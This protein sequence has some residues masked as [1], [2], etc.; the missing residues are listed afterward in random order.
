M[1]KSLLPLV[2]LSASVISGCASLPAAT[3]ADS[4]VRSV[5]AG[6]SAKERAQADRQVVVTFRDVRPVLAIEAGATPTLQASRAGYASSAYARRIVGRLA[7]DYELERVTD[8]FIETLGVHCVVYRLV[9][10]NE[11]RDTL[12]AKLRSDKRVAD[13]Q[14]MQEFRTLATPA[15]TSPG[16]TD[17]YLDLQH[18]AARIGVPA[19][20]KHASGRGIRVAVVDTGLDDLHTDLQGR[21]ESTD[22]FVDNDTTQYRRDRHGTAVGGTIAAN[23]GNGK[24][25]RGVAPQARLVSLKACWE[26]NEDGAAACN[27]LTLAGALE[28]AIRRKVH[29]I[30]LSL[31]GPADPLLANLLRKA[32]DQGILVV[33]ASPEAN[34]AANGFPSNVRGVIA[35]VNADESSK[36]GAA[37]AAPGDEV[38]TLAPG[39]RYDFASGVSISTAMVSGVVALL[40]EKAPYSQHDE[41]VAQLPNLL[42]QT[43]DP[44]VARSPEINAARAI[45]AALR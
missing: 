26:V 27:S 12:L 3:T 23:S 10:A 40:L 35:V 11:D 32:I 44:R 36:V 28:S 42:R 8:W 29:V 5:L 9:V 17:P 37:V 21:V 7:E 2:V 18:A 45:Q 41:F 38:L 30:N 20:Q 14:P 13:A 31:A 16:A 39:G 24:G 43:A 4:A 6:L 1:H 34:E 15:A 19:A 25:I 33:A 22:N